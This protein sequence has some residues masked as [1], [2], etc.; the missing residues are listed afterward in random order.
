MGHDNHR[1]RRLKAKKL[2]RSGLDAFVLPS[3][4]D[5]DKIV[6]LE[7]IVKRNLYRALDSL[8]RIRVGRTRSESSQPTSSPRS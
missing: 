4:S 6:R 2:R 8:E 7:R 5:V 1:V 3:Y